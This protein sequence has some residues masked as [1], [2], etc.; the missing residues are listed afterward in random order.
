MSQSTY[1]YYH[2]DG[3]GRLHGAELFQAAN[4]DDAVAQVKNM[5][6]DVMCEIWQG[7]RL[8][9]KLSPKRRQA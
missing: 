1:R 5:L 8:V 7:A 4:D 9:A 2:L 3:V 6:P